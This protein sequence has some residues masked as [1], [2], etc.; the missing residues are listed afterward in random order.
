MDVG[1]TAGPE[2]EQ[3][4]SHD[5]EFT[6]VSAADAIERLK[7][8]NIRYLRRSEIHGDVS[9]LIRV[10]T[11]REGQHPYAIVVACSDSRVIPEIIFS[12]GIG[13][14]FVVRVAGNVIDDHQLGSIQ[15]AAEHLHT[16]LVLV[17]GHTGCGAVAAAL[18]GAHGGFIGKLTDEIRLAIGTEKDPYEACCLNVSRSV[19]K[20]HHW[21]KGDLHEEVTVL[22]VVYDIETGR[23]DFDMPIWED[24]NR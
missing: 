10:R 8:G 22:G 2:K 12:A 7:I 17:L 13:D 1:R 21:L 6:P 4:M 15:Y 14:L 24:R 3:A 16:R 11:A 5:T 9:D 19:S 23:V 20:I 18:E